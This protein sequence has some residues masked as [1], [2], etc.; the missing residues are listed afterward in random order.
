MDT[1]LYQI[2]HI[3]PEETALSN[4]ISD[5]ATSFSVEDAS[6]L[7]SDPSTGDFYLY[8]K[9]EFMVLDATDATNDTVNV[10]RGALG[11][12]P[13]EHKAGDVVY[14]GEIDADGVDDRELRRID[15]IANP[16]I[17]EIGE[18]EQN[19]EYEKA[20]FRISN[21]KVTIN[22][23]PKDR[24][25]DAGS[26]HRP[27]V[28]EIVDDTGT[29]VFSGIVDGESVSFTASSRNTSFDVLSWL[30]LLD[31]AGSVPARDVF[32]VDV[33]GTARS[34]SDSAF[35]DSNQD[36]IQIKLNNEASLVGQVA[37]V[38]DVAVIETDES[39]IRKQIV[40][41]ETDEDD[42]VV[43][44]INAKEEG[45]GTDVVRKVPG[46]GSYSTSVLMVRVGQTG[47]SDLRVRITD[48]QQVFDIIEAVNGDLG[49]LPSG[50]SKTV[51]VPEG[52]S[53]EVD[54]KYKAVALNRFNNVEATDERSATVHLDEIQVY[55]A[56]DD[57][58]IEFTKGFDDTINTGPR[59]NT[60][61]DEV[62]DQEYRVRIKRDST[63]RLAEDL[64]SDSTVRILGQ[65]IYGYNGLTYFDQVLYYDGQPLI[66]NLFQIEAATTT[67]RAQLGVL[68][69]VFDAAS[70]DSIND[71]AREASIDPRVE[72][73][74]DPLKALRQIQQRR[75]FLLKERFSNRTNSNGEAIPGYYP[76]F[77]FR[78]GFFDSAVEVSERKVKEWTENVSENDVRAVIVKPNEDY[79]K[80]RAGPDV[81]E[82]IGFYFEGISRYEN[83]DS[84]DIRDRMSPP[85]GRN[86]IEIEMPIIPSEEIGYKYR[87]G[88][89]VENN[90]K[91]RYVAKFFYEHFTKASREVEI[92]FGDDTP[93]WIGGYWYFKNQGD[94]IDDYVF[95]SQET[96][97]VDSTSIDASLKGRIGQ[98]AATIDDAPPTAV[99]KGPKEISR[100]NSAGDV[101]VVL[102][103]DES[104]SLSGNPL[105]FT[106][107]RKKVG[108][109]FSEVQSN[110]S[111][112]KDTVSGVDRE[113]GYVYRL[114]VTDDQTGVTD[115]VTHDLTV[116]PNRNE[117]APTPQN[118]SFDVKTW[119]QESDGVLEVIPNQFNS[120]DK[121][122]KRSKVG[123][124][125]D[126]GAAFSEVSRFQVDIASID[127]TN[128]EVVLT[129]D[130]EE[131]FDKPF[132]YAKEDDAGGTTLFDISDAT[133]DSGANETT[134]SLAESIDSTR[135]DA[136]ETGTFVMRVAL[137]TKHTSAIEIRTTGAVDGTRQT[138][139]H[140]F[141]FDNLA[142]VEASVYNDESG[143]VYADVRGDEDTDNF[144]L[145]Y[146]KNGGDWQDALD[147]QTN[148]IVGYEVLA[149]DQVSDGDQV[150]V[151]ITPYN[152]DIEQGR[153][154]TRAT[155]YN[156]STDGAAQFDGVN[157]NGAGTI[158]SV[159]TGEFR[160]RDENGDDA[161]KIDVFNI[162][163]EQINGVAVGNYARADQDETFT[164]DVTIQNN[165]Y[166]Q[167]TE[168]ITNTETVDVTD[169]LLFLNRGETGNG[170]TNGIVGF[171]ADRGTQPP[172]KLIFDE[173]GDTGRIGV[174]YKTISY[175]SINNG[176]FQ[177][178][179]E[180]EGQ[181]SG[182]TAYLWEVDDANNNIRT[183]G[184][185]STFIDGETI[186]G[187]A[188][189]ATATVDSVSQYDQ[190]Q[191]LAVVEDS[192]VGELMEWNASAGELQSSGYTA[193][194]Y[195]A[196]A[197]NE[198]VTGN[199]AF[200]N[201]V[202]GTPGFDNNTIE[203]LSSNSSG[204]EKLAISFHHKPNTSQE[205]Y[206]TESGF[207]LASRVWIGS[208][209]SPSGAHKLEVDGEIGYN[210]SS[211]ILGT[212]YV[213]DPA[214]DGGSFAEFDNMRIRNEFRT[215][216]FKKDIV[217]A[218]NGYL[219]IT[220]SAEIAETKTISG[221]ADDT[222]RIKDGNG[223]ATFDS[224]DLLW[225]KSISDDGFTIYGV[226]MTV[227]GVNT[228]GTSNGTSYTEYTVSADGTNESGGNVVAGDTVVKVGASSGANGYL[229]N[230]A[231][232]ANSPFLDV[233]DGVTGWGE[234]T[235]SDKLK[236][237]LGNLAGA[238]NLSNG[239][240]PSGYGL[241]SENVF[242]EGEIVAESGKFTDQ[243]TVGDN[244]FLQ[245]ASVAPNGEDEI[246]VSA[247]GGSGTTDYTRIFAHPTDNSFG[248]QGQSGGNTTFFLGF[249][250][251]SPA[252]KISSFNFTPNYLT[253]DNVYIGQN[254]EN[255]DNAG[256]LLVGNYLGN[257]TI[258]ATGSGGSG[259][260]YMFMSPNTG[261]M[262]EIRE[263]GNP[264]MRVQDNG[265]AFL[266]NAEI[267]GNVSVAGGVT[268]GSLTASNLNDTAT[269]VP[270]NLYGPDARDIVTWSD[271]FDTTPEV[272]D[273]QDAGIDGGDYVSVWVEM[274]SESGTQSARCKIRGYD[275]GGAATDFASQSKTV[276]TS[277]E[278]IK[279][280]GQIPSDSVEIQVQFVNDSETAD[281]SRQRLVVVKGPVP[282]GWVTQI[283][284]GTITAQ[285]VNV[286]S[287]YSVNAQVTGTLTIG[288]GSTGA[289]Q[290]YNYD[291]SQGWQI[292][293][294]T[295][296]FED[297]KFRG[298]VNMEAG[299]LSDLEVQGQ[300]TF[301][302]SYDSSQIRIGSGSDAF[303]V[304]DFSLIGSG[305]GGG[306]PQCAASVSD[307]SADG[308]ATTG[309][310]LGDY[311]ETDIG[312]ASVTVDVSWDSNASSSGNLDDTIDPNTQVS[313]TIYVRERDGGSLVQERSKTPAASLND[314]GTASFSFTADSSTDEIEVETEL[315]ASL[316]QDEEFYDSVSISNDDANVD[317]TNE[318][319]FVGPDGAIW[320]YN[321]A[322]KV[323]IK[324]DYN[325][326][327]PRLEVHD[328][329]IT[330]YDSNGNPSITLKG[331]GLIVFN[332]KRGHPS[333]SEMDYE[334]GAIYAY[335]AGG[336]NV[337]FGFTEDDN[338]SHDTF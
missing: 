282:R 245:D 287:L 316:G 149:G 69:Q 1:R 301:P 76:E 127:T 190:T 64:S 126:K 134:I 318:Q 268:I 290:S 324:G 235:S 291:G 321:G 280:T 254:L 251:G 139:T 136:V 111:I 18:I 59:S 108:G 48:D 203:L 272:I 161:A 304:G 208:Y 317:W 163:L 80:G 322:T 289:V 267:R 297:G 137:S 216:I 153:Q 105:S 13:R 253:D 265:T 237:R 227:T 41:R 55:G 115:S 46:A 189:G 325:S 92:T 2:A 104:F 167:G 275:S 89:T 204:D 51:S 159:N 34:N 106:W 113:V 158:D 49:S 50:G 250:N 70:Y 157:I 303:F 319:D 238:P 302:S 285:Q 242:L 330:V 295:A 90:P 277:W 312:G 147:G 334:E 116:A 162:E 39:E 232:S 315:S 130:Y 82:R 145:E 23:L 74:D 210:Y 88:D 311:N 21:C 171:E 263:G 222:L 188:S 299:T 112:L 184:R 53:V 307:S 6:T 32:E 217:R 164:G 151:R 328:G 283:R 123:G 94:V 61:V 96:K 142:E 306:A 230:D 257:P 52:F 154:I 140:T 93:E 54:L 298:T 178:H 10:T 261:T 138:Q 16:D 29:V 73:P 107:E 331:N 22:G 175:S 248:I 200:E 320:R 63:Q 9:G 300:L 223:N 133:Y 286:Q 247:S 212:G 119:Q 252:H 292:K 132:L 262:F 255:K 166:V 246:R 78:D 67:G 310:G 129:G 269:E 205:L 233:Y 278:V 75:Q 314:S 141:D 249:V 109:T 71:F 165:L 95:I 98:E 187:K 258:K 197:E 7:P 196:L 231:S 174:E 65:E 191:R 333:A 38:G 180:I 160:F 17:K 20:K 42:R 219:L 284:D 81:E 199:W 220:D 308:T 4:D 229:Y 97:N 236:V 19:L 8:V 338:T 243:F 244:V 37:Q 179:E 100:A 43:I 124:N 234:F 103:G 11:T 25:Q 36:D 120:L 110:G 296:E 332:K 31:R 60:P 313:I 276:G 309:G 274:R 170:V 143:A 150:D 62:E 135:F 192:P 84:E 194:D 148:S 279:Y 264:V 128:N 66:K 193:D 288:D 86:V 177:V 99:V 101:Q 260:D 27:W 327:G 168:F 118:Q 183:K 182:A 24:L 131:H 83:A 273:L 122:E 239:T 186:E 329:D 173:S 240:S 28:F 146:R 57:Y 47:D 156:R 155:F 271:K 26:V 44:F 207:T 30:E 198:F 185:T 121:V 176:P 14:E 337:N 33:Y 58:Y 195:G 209:S 40:R 224:G 114:T 45:D 215:H 326:S 202:T 206:T 77:V 181:N 226:K 213:I 201:P 125:I 225:V 85:E 72:L 5:S 35:V 293:G 305:Q 323:K 266:D 169:N 117:A 79:L 15:E 241:Y 336:G 152:A 3:P 270:V 294:D 68:P 221:S 259:T 56:N 87:G 218:S 214:S 335:D 172:V 228:T 102:N 256:N 91:L 12:S 144:D 211:G 281:M